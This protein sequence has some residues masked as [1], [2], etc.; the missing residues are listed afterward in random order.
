MIADN[1]SVYFLKLM[2]SLSSI[3]ISKYIIAATLFIIGLLFARIISQKFERA[4]LKHLSAHHAMLVRRFLYTLILLLFFISGLQQLGFQFGVLLGAAGVFTVAISFASQTSI[5]NLISGIF[6]LIER[7]F[8]VGDVILVKNMTGKVHSIDLLST[9]IVSPDNKLIRLPNESLIKTEIIN[10][11]YFPTRRL[12]FTVG[13]A[14]D[15]PLQE[16]IAFIKD[17]IEKQP[18]A[19]P[20]PKSSVDINDLQDSAIELKCCVWVELKNFKALKTELIKQI[21]ERLQ[22]EGIEIPFPQVVVH[23][24]ASNDQ[25]N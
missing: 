10:L 9:K 3:P 4:A 21:V 11:N 14:Y 6:L 24:T 5:S 15:S 18:L 1:Q 22:Q 13:V 2:T 12:E 25:Q 7:P 23:Q 16:T 17:E 19:L 8:K 20:D